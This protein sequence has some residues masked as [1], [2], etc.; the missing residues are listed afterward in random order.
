M[1]EKKK[2]TED[3]LKGNSP[4]KYPKPPPLLIAAVGDL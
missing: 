4:E 2:R 1:K 3:G